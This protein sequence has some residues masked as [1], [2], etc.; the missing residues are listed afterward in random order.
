MREWSVC[1]HNK[2][3]PRKNREFQPPERFPTSNQANKLVR[4][5]TGTGDLIGC[6]LSVDTKS[7]FVEKNVNYF[8]TRFYL[9]FGECVTHS[10]SV[11]CFE[12]NLN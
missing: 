3:P 4:V 10:S 2:R 7:S 5:K 8:C 6:S 9:I 1:A 11:H 12:C